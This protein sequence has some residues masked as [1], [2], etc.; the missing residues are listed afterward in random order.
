VALAETAETAGM[1]NKE[2]DADRSLAAEVHFFMVAAAMQRVVE[3]V[4]QVEARVL[5]G[6]LRLSLSLSRMRALR[7]LPTVAYPRNAGPVR[8]PQ[9]CRELLG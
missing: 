7:P 5:E 4:V 8:D 3:Q 9:A 2:A 6:R 1:V